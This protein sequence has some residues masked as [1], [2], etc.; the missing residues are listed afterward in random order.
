MEGELASLVLVPLPLPR[1]RIPTHNPHLHLHLHIPTIQLFSN[2]RFIMEELYFYSKTKDTHIIL[3]SCHSLEM[4]IINWYY[5]LFYESC[6]FSLPYF[7]SGLF[8]QI[9]YNIHCWYALFSVLFFVVGSLL[10]FYHRFNLSKIIL[11][12]LKIWFIS[13]MLYLLLYNM[14]Y[15]Y[16]T[17]TITYN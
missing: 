7:V 4:D 10:N 2:V 6:N 14:Y 9:Y 1:P 8:S 13:T 15:L 12:H 17:I 5:L 16:Y 3:V 11:K